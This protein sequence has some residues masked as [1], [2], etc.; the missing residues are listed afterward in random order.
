M[1]LVTHDEMKLRVGKQ[2]K[3]CRPESQP[4]AEL[5]A[6]LDTDYPYDWHNPTRDS[7]P[8]ELQAGAEE[9]SRRFHARM[10]LLW[11]SGLSNSIVVPLGYVTWHFEGHATRGDILTNTWKLNTGAGGADDPERP[12]RSTQDY[13]SW[14]AVLPYAGVMQCN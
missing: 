2:W 3:T 4:Q 11:G 10:Y 9:I 14:S 12:Y 13:P 7:P 5:G 8:I 6:G 1:Q